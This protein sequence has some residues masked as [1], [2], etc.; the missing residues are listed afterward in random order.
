MAIVSFQ[1]CLLAMLFLISCGQ[2][3]CSFM[4]S[5][6]WNLLKF[7][8]WLNMWTV[9]MFFIFVWKEFM[10]GCRDLSVYVRFVNHAIRVSIL[11]LSSGY[12]SFLKSSLKTYYGLFFRRFCLFIFR[13]REREGKRE[14]NINVWLPL[15][16]PP[17]HVPW[18]GVEPVTLWFVGHRHSSTEPHQPGETMV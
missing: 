9:T 14:G 12:T 3:S 8:F 13:E 18:L 15:T 16:R 4:I 10:S 6:L 11:N 7:S 1:I 5:V 2:R 17:R